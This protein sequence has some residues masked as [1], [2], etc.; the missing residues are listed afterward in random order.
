M[1]IHINIQKGKKRVITRLIQILSA[2]LKK[3]RVNWKDTTLKILH[4]ILY[5]LEISV[6]I[7]FV[8]RLM[9]LTNIFYFVSYQ[10]MNYEGSLT[11][12]LYCPC[13]WCYSLL[14]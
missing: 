12:F 9:V 8:H 1:Q 3:K 4:L 13:L 11:R 7:L 2:N 10:T 5:L 14:C 6:M